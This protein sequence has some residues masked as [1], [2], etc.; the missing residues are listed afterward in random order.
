[1][2]LLHGRWRRY[3][4]VWL[5]ELKN[6]KIKSKWFDVTTVM[7]EGIHMLLYMV[8]QRNLEPPKGSRGRW[9]LGGSD[10]CRGWRCVHHVGTK[11]WLLCLD[12][13]RSVDPT[14][15][16]WRVVHGRARGSG[17][18]WIDTRRERGACRSETS[19]LVMIMRRVSPSDG[20][21]GMSGVIL[22]WYVCSQVSMIGIGMENSRASLLH[23]SLILIPCSPRMINNHTY[24]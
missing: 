12:L 4:L 5:V 23:R 13:I 6:V 2:N 15:S 19:H 22:C 20:A 10:S 7:A 18:R 17:Y 14:H 9:I 1:M 8:L 21:R 24:F 3:W 11:R 16:C